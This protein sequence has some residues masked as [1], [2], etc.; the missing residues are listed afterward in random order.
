VQ[1]VRALQEGV[2]CGGRYLGEENPCGH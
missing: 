2:S 1:D